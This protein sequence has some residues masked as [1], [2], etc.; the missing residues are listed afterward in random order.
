M[1]LRPILSS[2]PAPPAMLLCNWSGSA[3]KA[4][5]T[6][7][8]LSPY[9]GKLKSSIASSLIA[10]FTELNDLVYDP[11]SGSGTVALEAWV[12]G[13]RIIANDLSP[14]AALLTRAKLFPYESLEDAVDDM[15]DFADE[16]DS[17]ASYLDMRRVPKWV[18]EFFHPRTLRETLAWTYVLSHGRDLVT[19]IHWWHNLSD[20]EQKSNQAPS[21]KSR[22]RESLGRPLVDG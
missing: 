7:H 4:E 1:E 13:R 22:G 8:Q 2:I 6:F 11:F 3:L 9:I 17:L 12:A 21:C 19:G 14:Y 18:R 20:A 5:S 10:Q 16:A 15:D